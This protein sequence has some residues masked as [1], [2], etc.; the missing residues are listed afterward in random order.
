MHINIYS[1]KSFKTISKIK[2]IFWIISDISISLIVFV[3]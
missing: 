2:S 3:R 1:I